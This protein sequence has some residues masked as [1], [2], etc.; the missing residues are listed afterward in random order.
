MDNE[1][2]KS[3]APAPQRE[4]ST[5]NIVILSL[6]SMTAV[7]LFLLFGLSSLKE[8]SNTPYFTFSSQDTHLS[9]HYFTDIKRRTLK[10]VQSVHKVPRQHRRIVLVT[11][12]GSGHPLT[13]ETIHITNLNEPL[14]TGR[15]G[16]SELEVGQ[17]LFALDLEGKIQREEAEN[18]PPMPMRT[19]GRMPNPADMQRMQNQL[20]N[21]DTARF[22]NPQNAV[23]LRMMQKCASQEGNS[24]S[25]CYKK[26]R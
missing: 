22:Q 20:E 21:V 8:E 17:V 16:A 11:E 2:Q 24:P 6:L 13:A 7:A 14:A 23:D 1:P 19:S 12:R 10:T 25:D 18:R 4:S 3:F 15:Y 5:M 9:F 26:A